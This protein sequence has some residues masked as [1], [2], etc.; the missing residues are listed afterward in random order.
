LLYSETKNR[1]YLNLSG[2]D[3]V[4]NTTAFEMVFVIKSHVN[5][6]FPI[7]SKQK[8]VSEIKVLPSALAIERKAHV[9]GFAF[10]WQARRLLASAKRHRSCTNNAKVSVAWS[11]SALKRPKN[12]KNNN[13]KLI[14][15]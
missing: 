4:Q 13:K 1:S 3:A 11:E 10:V 8:V 2:F 7:N 12:S 15:E 14:R 6:C 5:Q 9:E